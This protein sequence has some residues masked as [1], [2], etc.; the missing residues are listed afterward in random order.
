MKAAPG[1][2]FYNRTGVAKSHRGLSRG[3]A[4]FRY[5]GIGH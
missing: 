1:S 3:R 2:A 4:P 5:I